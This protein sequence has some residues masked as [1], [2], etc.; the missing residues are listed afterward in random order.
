MAYRSILQCVHRNGVLLLAA[1][2]VLYT[3][4][5]GFYLNKDDARSSLTTYVCVL[6]GTACH[7]FAVF[8][9]VQPSECNDAEL[10]SWLAPLQRLLS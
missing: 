7:Y 1:G 4:G 3:I 10:E 8:M 9:Y 2:G 5:A 6:L